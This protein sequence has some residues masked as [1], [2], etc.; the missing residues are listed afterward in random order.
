MLTRPSRSVDL[1][2]LDLREYRNTPLRGCSCVFA[3]FALAKHFRPGKEIRDPS[4]PE[5]I[6]LWQYIP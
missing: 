3:P 5:N 1:A 4:F 6:K 2:K